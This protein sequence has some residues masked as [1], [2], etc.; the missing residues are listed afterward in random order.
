MLSSVCINVSIDVDIMV[1]S[2]ISFNISLLIS[3]TI[4][5][6]GTNIERL[7]KHSFLNNLN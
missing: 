1:Y 6:V 2:G 5:L 3:A 7:A 4:S